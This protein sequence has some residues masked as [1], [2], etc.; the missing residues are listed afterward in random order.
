MKS[1]AVGGHDLSRRYC[2]SSVGRLGF[3]FFE[4]EAFAVNADD[5]AVLEES[6][7]DGCGEDFVAG[8]HFTG[9]NPATRRSLS[10]ELLRIGPGRNDQLL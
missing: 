9:L 5:V 10:L 3:H 4:S 1:P 6:V 8:Q 7:E 2:W